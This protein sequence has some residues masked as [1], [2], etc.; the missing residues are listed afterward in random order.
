VQSTAYLVAKEEINDLFFV[1]ADEA[2]NLI[3]AAKI[4]VNDSFIIIPDN[5]LLLKQ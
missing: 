3:K 4:F 5:N 1:C 2:S